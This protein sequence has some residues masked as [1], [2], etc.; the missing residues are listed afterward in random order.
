MKRLLTCAILSLFALNL[1]YA[2][3]QEKVTLSAEH[4][5]ERVLFDG[6]CNV[7]VRLVDSDDDGNSIVAM[8]VENLMESNVLILFGH[9]YL[10]KDLKR[11]SPSITFDKTFL[12]GTKGD[13]TIDTYKESRN[14]FFIEYSDKRV[15][16]KVQV[17]NGEVHLCRLPLY[18]AKY[19]DKNLLI[20]SN[21]QNKMLLMDK[22]IFELE[23]VVVVRPDEDYARLEQKADELVEEIG[24]QTFCNNPKHKPSLDKQEAP[25]KEKIEKIKSEID[26]II[27]RHNWY[28]SDRGYQKYD[29]IKQKLD[30][31]DFAANEKDCGKRHGG[32]SNSPSVPTVPGCKY[33][34]LSPQQIY[35]K[36]DDYY[37]KI[38]NSNDRKATKIAVMNDV[39]L[40]YECRKH[41]ASWKNSEYQSKITDRY[42]RICNF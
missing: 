27:T 37:K 17:K 42:N 25:Y 20:G 26:G 39:N 21:G 7:F 31:I 32:G 24:R 8:E 41:A 2:D 14:D 28:S 19:K 12:G 35:N 18:I 34:G 11:L 15:L 1:V 29:G 5:E 6:V 16:P 10:E 13:R 9:A 4:S 40:L 30:A 23:V 22:Q 36:L 3:K 33:C 38:Y